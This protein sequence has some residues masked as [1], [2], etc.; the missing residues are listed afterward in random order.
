MELK[1]LCKRCEG[2]VEPKNITKCW[3]Y[4]K[5]IDKP[6]FVDGIIEQ[7]RKEKGRRRAQ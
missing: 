5:K 6:M 3:H 4:N 1:G 7:W 2:C